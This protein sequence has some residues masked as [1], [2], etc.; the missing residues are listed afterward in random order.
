KDRVHECPRC[1][2]R[3][4]RDLNAALNILTLG[5]RGRACGDAG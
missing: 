5:L 3:L 2:L 1:G 4:D